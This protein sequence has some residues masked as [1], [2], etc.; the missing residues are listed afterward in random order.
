MD[1]FYNYVFIIFLFQVHYNL[2]YAYKQLGNSTEAVKHMKEAKKLTGEICE[3][4]HSII[5]PALDSLLVIIF[6]I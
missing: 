2:S 6:Y 5:A 3:T 4:K 1:I